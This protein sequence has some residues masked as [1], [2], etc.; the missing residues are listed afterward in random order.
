MFRVEVDLVVGCGL[1]VVIVVVST[2]A[3]VLAR[4][5]SRSAP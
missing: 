4:S 3:N 1:S 2:N 5:S